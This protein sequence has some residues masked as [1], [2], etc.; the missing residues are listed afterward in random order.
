MERPEEP[1]EEYLLEDLYTSPKFR[2]NTAKAE[3]MMLLRYGDDLHP[4]NRSLI[5]TSNDFLSYKLEL[6]RKAQ[7]EIRR[8]RQLRRQNR[9]EL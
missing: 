5:G 1:V 2:I 9:A 8:Q 6:K 3:S 4:L 7:R